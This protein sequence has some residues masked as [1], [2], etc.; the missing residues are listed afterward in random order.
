MVTATL[1]LLLRGPKLEAV[2]LTETTGDVMRWSTR[3]KHISRSSHVLRDTAIQLLSSFLLLCLTFFVYCSV[4]SCHENPARTHVDRTELE[5]QPVVRQARHAH[6]ADMAHGHHRGWGYWHPGQF[7]PGYFPVAPWMGPGFHYPHRYRH[8][9][10]FPTFLYYAR[11]LPPPY[12]MGWSC[13]AGVG[14]SWPSGN[15]PC[16][17]CGRT[18]EVLPGERVQP[19]EP[20]SENDG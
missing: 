19:N 13:C 2:L 1:R 4:G 9:Y 14:A 15:Q 8:F 10:Y 17:Y 18:G 12:P 11:P 20:A 7:A 3:S 6:Q 5:L 16:P